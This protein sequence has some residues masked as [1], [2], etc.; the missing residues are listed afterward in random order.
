[1]NLFYQ[2]VV[3]KMN[4]CNKTRLFYMHIIL[5]VNNMDNGCDYDWSHI[6]KVDWLIICFCLWI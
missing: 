3:S 4:I 1:M 6:N 2:L 5:T